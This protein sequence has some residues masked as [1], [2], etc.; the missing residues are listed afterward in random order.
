MG[1]GWPNEGPLRG[2]GGLGADEG[3]RVPPE[4][5]REDEQTPGAPGSPEGSDGP[6]SGGLGGTRGRELVGRR[7]RIF[8]AGSVDGGRECSDQGGTGAWSHPR[9]G[10]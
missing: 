5:L 8:I 1:G 4:D 10:R 3:G 2:C 9:I 6:Y 7:S